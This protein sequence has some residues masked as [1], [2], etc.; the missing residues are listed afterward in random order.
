MHRPWRC[1][2]Q[3]LI[4]EIRTLLRCLLCY[5]PCLL[6]PAAASRGAPPSKYRHRGSWGSRPQ[7]VGVFIALWLPQNSGNTNLEAFDYLKPGAA[8]AIACEGVVGRCEDAEAVCPHRCQPPDDTEAQVVQW[9]WGS[10]KTLDSRAFQGSL[11]MHVSE[12]Q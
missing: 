2:D 6:G 7:Q 1:G 9:D 12:H 5:R 4:D 8:E 10:V 11:L 3:K